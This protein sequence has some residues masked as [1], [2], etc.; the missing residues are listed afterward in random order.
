MASKDYDDLL[1]SFMNN[2]SKVYDEDKNTLEEKTNKVP[3]S[4][5]ASSKSDKAKKRQV[6][7]R[8]IEEE[9]TAKKKNK[10]Q[11]PPKQYDSPTKRVLAQI[12]KALVGC[13]M[14][15]AVVAVV[16]VSV[17]MIY[18]YSV[19]YGDPVFDLTEEKHSQNQTSFIYGTDSKGK[20]V[21]IT[22]LHGIENRIWVDMDDMSEY[23][24]K[25]FI[26]I[27][28]KRFNSHSGVDWIRTVKVTTEM[29]GQGGSTMT[30]QL[31]KNLTDEDQV[32]F[33]RKFNEILQALNLERNYSKDEI[34]EA[35]M[36]TLYLSHGCYGVKTAAET[37]F[38]KELEDLNIAEC[39]SIAAIT[40]YPG[41]YDPLKNPENNKKRQK[42]VLDNMLEE[43]FITQSEYDEAISYEMIFTNSKNYKGS[44]L[45]NNSGKSSNES[46]NSYYVDFVISSVMEDLQ[47][48]G[49]SAKKAKNLVYGGGLKIYSAMDFNVQKAV[50]KVYKNYE[51]MPDKKIQ[52]AMCIMDYEG[53]VLGIVGGTGKKKANLVLN[54]ASQSERQPGS[55]IKPLSVYAPALEK[56]LQDDSCN[57]YWSTLIKDAPLMEVDG[58]MWPK[59]QGSTSGNNVTLQY[60]LAKSLNT[61]AA[62]TLDM[63]SDSS[64]V[65]YSLDYIMDRFH[66]STLDSVKDC[67]YAPMATGAVTTGVSVLEMTA[68][69]AAFGNGG[70]YYE[71]YSYYKIEDSMGNVLIEQKPD[72]TKQEAMS[73]NTAWVMNKLL[74]TVMTSGTGTSY[75]LSNIQCF[76]KT[77][78]TTEDKDRWFVGGTPNYVA[79]VWYGYDKPKEIRYNL[80]YN[81]SG[82]IWKTVMNDVYS[83]L[84]KDDYKSKFPEPK[85][86]VQ[87]S[88]CPSCGKLKSGTGV[89]G[90]YDVNNLPGY[91]SG[92]ASS[93]DS[94]S[95]GSSK[96]K[97]T[98]PNKNNGGENTSKPDATKPNNDTTAAP[99]PPANSGGDDE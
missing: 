72:K 42:T 74:Q 19:V 6:R 9:L 17:V 65:N 60:G 1:Q 26:A 48:M 27:E 75:K 21:E 53:R 57:I 77:G 62:R 97:T 7:G 29:N 44:Q 18:G 8:K 51:K 47:K 67:D 85:G 82:T 84:G 11:K 39:A 25:A 80:S 88:Y 10:K 61:V 98:K 49:Y 32:T 95:S 58:K 16:C 91:C 73:E 40:Q 81:P 89:Y 45:K 83:S 36:N 4:Y 71:P 14:V 78:T 24:A 28:D 92:H 96:D 55:T 70:Q 68:A 99:A 5:N 33:I 22:R 94:G 63:I 15:V 50:E 69:F 79:A 46:V 2:S 87:K 34:I 35:Y 38:G 12:G 90:W 56:S 86:I 93:S 59:N 52:G 3:S 43:G 54:R 41:K 64:G 66:I 20:S 13:I 23:M 37:Y 30:Q 76:G 31:I